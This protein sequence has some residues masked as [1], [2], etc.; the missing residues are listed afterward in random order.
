MCTGKQ[1]E[2][3]CGHVL[4]HYETR[5]GRPCKAPEGPY[6]SV[7]D[8]CAECDEE[9][10]AWQK[11]KT[12][13]SREAELL[14][15]FF[16]GD[17]EEHY[18]STRDCIKKMEALN[19]NSLLASSEDGKPAD[20]SSLE[21]ACA[22]KLESMEFWGVA[23]KNA[24]WENGKLVWYDYKDTY[25]NGGLNRILVKHEIDVPAKKAI[26]E[27]YLQARRESQEERAEAK[28]KGIATE[29]DDAEREEEDDVP[30][31]SGA[32]PSAGHGVRHKQSTDSDATV[33][34]AKPQK[35]QKKHRA[36][37]RSR[38][39][40][41]RTAEYRAEC[42]SPEEEYALSDMWQRMAL[43]E[44]KGKQPLQRVDDHPVRSPKPQPQAS[45][46]K[47]QS[48]DLNKP[49]AQASRSQVRAENSL[50]RV[51]KHI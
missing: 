19:Q 39:V 2:M 25:I 1:M 9:F 50:R 37:G 35:P 22:A 42:L 30:M 51:T 31:M 41:L 34:P 21:V 20:S 45:L 16:H 38:T 23:G 15:Q 10:K 40:K 17:A 43:D 28:G 49:V 24:K 27:K 8:P 13:K 6:S 11:N 14:D 46:E 26:V 12:Y 48:G 47:R 29:E 32:L 4:Q 44:D 36:R 3:S 5:C 33:V 18:R 7:D